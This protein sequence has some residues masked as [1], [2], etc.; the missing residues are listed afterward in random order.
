MITPFNRVRE[1][2]RRLKIDI[3]VAPGEYHLSHRGFPDTV[4]RCLDLNDALLAGRE[5][6]KNPPE[7]PDPPPGPLGSPALAKQ[8]AKRIRHNWAVIGRKLKKKAAKIE[9]EITTTLKRQK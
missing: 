2:L 5:M 1:E 8:R 9:A 6:A 7:P 3:R 4:T